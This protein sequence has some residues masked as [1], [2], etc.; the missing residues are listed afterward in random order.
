MRK[1]ALLI[2]I[3]ILAL[4]LRI[5][6]LSQFPYG[7]TADEAA[8][9]YTAW[10]ILKTGCDEWGVK[11]P[12]NPR[13]FGD[14][15]P[16]LYT[17]LAI[18]SVAVFGLNEFAVR[19]PNALLGSLAVLLV[20]FLTK[21]LFGNKNHLPLIAA[22]LLTISPWHIS[23]SRGAFEANL[24]TF[25]LPLAIFFFIIGLRHSIF[26]VLSSFVF[27]LNL[28]TYH[29]AKLVTPLVL[30]LL[31]FFNK[32]KI[33]TQK[34]TAFVFIFSLFLG[35][36]FLVALKG[37]GTR[38]SDI[39]IFSGGWNDVAEARYYAKSLGLP[40]FVA[41]IFNNKAVFLF[42]QFFRNY[43]SYL[44]PQ[45]LFTQ[46]VGEATYGMIP[47]TGVLYLIELPF[48]IISFFCLF[49]KKEPA[50][51]FLWLWV[52]ASPIPAALA[53]GVGYHGNR[54]AVMMPAI[55]VV[56]AYGALK[57]FEFLRKK[58]S[59]KMIFSV[60]ALILFFSLSLFL[61]KYYFQA[62]KL[63]GPV[64]GFGWKEMMSY[65]STLENQYETIVVS[66]RFSEPQTMIAFFKKWE[67]SDFQEKSNDWLV[68]QEKNFYFV[69]QLPEY[70]LGKYFFK[71]LVFPED[72]KLKNALF[73]GKEEDFMGI[74]ANIKKVIYYP[75]YQK[76]VAAEIVDFQ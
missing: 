29:S 52:F 60:F 71:N 66:R 12:L 3:F 68:Y 34:L 48:I 27:G 43:F 16:P 61:E 22:L 20:Y 41:R 7:F 36:S 5:Y 63:N 8:Q 40:D 50:L 73:V 18:P 54:V 44:S 30:F 14:F 49:N 38:A 24:T 32:R 59:F 17:Y 51:I 25:F 64:M 4:L 58:F 72:A 6:K 76:K 23:L 26:L 70:R 28:F 69:D 53:R 37:G 21:E 47:G 75:G 67:P 31:L 65:V 9:G 15:K 42:E 39:G 13:S 11:F 10:S 45:F 62:P 55:Q 56:S 57:I 19:F 1:K 74:K 2:F 46:G 35:V 33:L